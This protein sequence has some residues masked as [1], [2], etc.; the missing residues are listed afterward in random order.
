M[1]SQIFWK[2]VDLLVFSEKIVFGNI[3]MQLIP[4]LLDRQ[5]FMMIKIEHN[6]MIFFLMNQSTV[7]E[8]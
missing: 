3:T 1:G 8:N 2:V 5:I 6:K 4:N 7:A